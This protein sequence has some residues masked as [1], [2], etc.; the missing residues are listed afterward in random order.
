MKIL[1]YTT[2]GINRNMFSKFLP[3]KY[4]IIT[5]VYLKYIFYYIKKKSDQNTP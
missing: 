2:N 1:N 5:R 3:E 4:P